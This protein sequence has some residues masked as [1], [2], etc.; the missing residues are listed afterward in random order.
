MSQKNKIKLATT[1]WA[2]TKKGP[3]KSVFP[4]TL[5]R[6]I[7]KA[8]TLSLGD[9]PSALQG[10]SCRKPALLLWRCVRRPETI[11]QREDKAKSKYSI[12]RE[13]SFINPSLLY[14]NFMNLSWSLLHI[15]ADLRVVYVH[16]WIGRPTSRWLVNVTQEKVKR[17]AA[18]YVWILL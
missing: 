14:L 11:P 7:N 13:W 12:H 5:D 6:S 10:L 17:P 9:L 3:M 1:F 15:S 4:I 2:W 16:T 18:T 8:I